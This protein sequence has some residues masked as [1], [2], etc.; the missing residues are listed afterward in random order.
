MVPV[1]AALR[2]R[3]A[4]AEALEA[5]CDKGLTL[6]AALNAPSWTRLSPRDRA[7]AR[8]IVSTALRQMGKIE[9]GLKAV[10][11]R[12][13]PPEATRANALL[14]C[15]IAELFL[16]DG[17]DYAVV[18]SLVGLSGRVD[19][20]R[21]Q[22][23]T[24]A[25]LRN[26]LREEKTVQAAIDA[27][28]AWPE[29]LMKSWQR[30]Y[31]EEKARAIA[32]ASAQEPALDLT[33]KGDP[34]ALAQRLGGEIVLG[35]SVRLSGGDPRALEGFDAGDWWVQDA[36]AAVPARLLGRIEGKRVLDLCAAPGGKTL[37]L[38]SLRA[39]V[40]A[41]DRSAKRLKRLHE[42]LERCGLTADVIE[43]NALVW[44][45]A[46]PFDAVLA[47]LPCSAT[48]TL[49]RQ[50]DVASNKG[51][52]DIDKLVRLQTEILKRLAEFAAPE[53]PVVICTCSLQPEEGEELLKA[54]PAELEIVPILPAEIPGLEAGL[55]P[56]GALRLTPDMEPGMDGFFIA[57]LV[58]I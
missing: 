57:R 33:A 34:A 47:D 21:Y 27:A 58:R 17:D 54:L 36:A 6:D 43:A 23:L 51:A 16:L 44:T 53:A 11:A 7:F 35:G 2:A 9:A 18:D 40:T 45:P 12:P 25:V 3:D 14:R 19:G 41:V 55:T 50:P 37:Q 1:P 42:N 32:H 39:D 56:E 20:G 26:A 15:G 4:V 52:Q 49:R 48:G 24:N 31:G 30:H 13:L 10:L 5:V 29:W 38:A 46:E 22:A 8:R 28:D